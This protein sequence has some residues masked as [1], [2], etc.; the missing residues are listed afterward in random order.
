MYPVSCN[1]YPSRTVVREVKRTGEVTRVPAGSHTCAEPVNAGEGTT[2]EVPTRP[3]SE[4]VMD[5]K[6]NRCLKPR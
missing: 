1:T 6:T 3:A 4:S 2:S 5:R